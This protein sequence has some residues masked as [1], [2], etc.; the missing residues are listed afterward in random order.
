MINVGVSDTAQLKSMIEE[1][2]KSGISLS[3]LGFGTG[4]YNEAMMEQIAD[5]GD[6]A[7]SYIDNLMEGH[8]V[9]VQ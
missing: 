1:K 4:N 8:K 7:Y 6:G 2:R 9:L 5:V 3:T